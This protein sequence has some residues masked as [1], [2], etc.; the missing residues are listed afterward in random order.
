M[1][2]L[3]EQGRGAQVSSHLVN[4]KRLTRTAG[5]TQTLEC[6]WEPR[7]RLAKGDWSQGA[8]ISAGPSKPYRGGL[9]H[10]EPPRKEMDSK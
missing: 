9:Y 6:R 3:V 8:D 4:R 1:P 10:S 2:S 7:L 5:I